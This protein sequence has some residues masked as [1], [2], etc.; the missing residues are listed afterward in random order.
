MREA[1]KYRS[2][3]TSVTS[4]GLVTGGSIGIFASN[5]ATGTSL[6]VDAV[7]KEDIKKLKKLFNNF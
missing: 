4:S 5:T 1:R 6:T 3:G 2:P 7:E